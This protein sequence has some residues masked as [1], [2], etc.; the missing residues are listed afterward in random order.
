VVKT[1]LLRKRTLLSKKRNRNKNSNLQRKLK[2]S[3]SSRK[4]V[5]P[6]L[7]TLVQLSP[8][9]SLLTLYVIYVS[10][11]LLNANLIPKVITFT[12]NKLMLVK[13]KA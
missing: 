12:S 3:Q 10:L 13:L 2:P 7:R 4:E 11:R 6:L 8:L 5:K 9:S 1:L